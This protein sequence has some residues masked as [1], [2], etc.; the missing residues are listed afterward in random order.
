MGNLC[1][2]ILVK[3]VK[4]TP[5]NLN[6]DNWLING[7]DISW[8]DT[9]KFTFPIKGGK[10]IKVYDGDTFTIAFKLPYDT[11]PLYRYSVRLKGIDT[12]EMKGKNEDE[13]ISAHKAQQALS[14]LILNKYIHLCNIDSDKYG[15]I[16]ADVYLDNLHI[17][18]WMI[19]KKLAVSYDGGTKISPNSWNNYNNL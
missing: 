10:V 14:D 2:N 8:K 5:V 13:K 9:I 7:N 3:E 4:L 1:K 12:P 19:D 16:L 18:Q 15:R 17:N 6:N 11:S